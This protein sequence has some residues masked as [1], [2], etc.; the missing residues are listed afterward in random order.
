M[1]DLPFAPTQG[2]GLYIE[3]GQATLIECSIFQNEASMNV[4]ARIFY[5][6]VTT[7]RANA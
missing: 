6:W 5:P 4:R 1:H 2:G 3:G 7:Q